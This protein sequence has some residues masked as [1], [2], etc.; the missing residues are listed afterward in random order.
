MKTA[1]RI[2]HPWEHAVNDQQLQ[3]TL[4]NLTKMKNNKS[5]NQLE[6]LTQSISYGFVQKQ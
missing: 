5:A 4:I 3:S 2:R 6:N 1:L